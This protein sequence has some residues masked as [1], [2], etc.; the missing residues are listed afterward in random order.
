MKTWGS[1]HSQLYSL[2]LFGFE[3][4]LYM[5]C[6][7]MFEKS[8]S[9]Q[10][11]RNCENRLVLPARWIHLHRGSDDLT[12]ASLLC[13]IHA[14]QC[15]LLSSVRFAYH[16]NSS[17]PKLPTNPRQP[18]PRPRVR[19]LERSVFKTPNIKPTS[20]RGLGWDEFW[21]NLSQPGSRLPSM[22]EPALS[23]QL[24]DSEYSS[25][26]RAEQVGCFHC[27]FGFHP[28]QESATRVYGSSARMWKSPSILIPRLQGPVEP[29][30]AA[31]RFSGC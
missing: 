26:L 22:P 2:I 9:R 25:R 13:R 18:H 14:L 8:A 19:M 7:H 3:A 20:L 28:T 31:S 17:N 11:S 30:I 10:A 24:L 29:H 12:A 23:P 21:H 15:S 1:Q 6:M 4:C 16:S 27:C 5:F